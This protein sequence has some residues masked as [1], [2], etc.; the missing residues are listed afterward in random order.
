[1]YRM[2]TQRWHCIAKFMTG[3]SIEPYDVEFKVNNREHV[4]LY[5]DLYTVSKPILNTNCN[6]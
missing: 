1:M 5:I 4:H 2:S 3:T 6:I